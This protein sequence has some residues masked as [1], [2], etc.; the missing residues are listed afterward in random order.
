ME[1]VRRQWHDLAARRRLILLVAGGTIALAFAASRLFGNTQA[2]DILMAVAALVA[3]ADI[4]LR[5]V[6][7]LRRRQV[8]IELLVTIAA[9][10]ALI[11]GEYWEA[12]A[13]TFL[14][15]LGAWLEARTLSRTRAALGKLLDLAPNVA[16]V[17]RGGRDVEV[18]P[19]DVAVGEEILVRSGT[20]IPVDGIVLRGHSAVDEAP[21]T[22]ESIPVE[23]TPGDAVFAGTISH[24][25]VLTI[26]ARG[27]GA[28]T[29]LA[30]II[31][32]V[33]EAQ[34]A[35]APAQKTIERFAAWYTPAIIALAGLTWAL[36]RDIHLALTILVIGCPGALVIATPV[37]FVAG[38]GRAA[39]QGILIKGGEFLETVGKVTTVGFDKTGTLTRGRPELT[40]IVAFAPVTVGGASASREPGMEVL[41]W[42]AIAEA[43]SGHPLARPIMTAAGE[44]LPGVLP[45]ADA[46]ETVVG[47]GVVATW[48]GHVIAVGTRDLMTRR[49]IEVTAEA[50]TLVHRLQSE[51]KTAML[52]GVDGAVVGVLGVQDVP[53]EDIAGVPA[54][55]ERA[56][57]RRIAMLTGDN[58][59][60][61]RTIGEAVGITEIH[62]RLLP[63]DK[64]A[65]IEAARARGEVVAMVGDGIN[66]APALA[67]AD[68]GIAMGAAGSDVALETADVALMT[69]Q[70]GKIADALR[71]SRRTVT[72][73]RQNL[74]IALVT[75]GLLL[76]GVLLR[77]VNMAGGMLI[78]EASVL[79]VILNAMRLLRA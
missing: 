59:E 73:I 36:T 31:H 20:K 58:A 17:R 60:T 61:A 72:V 22:G 78:H 38:I 6:H 19:A 43:G 29:T 21:I 65:W 33:E 77:E 75:V 54:R 9:G 57:I 49:D 71:I 64:L 32:R 74:A 44:R 23:K 45:A 55:L 53:R 27:I 70:P 50:D 79:L 11:I 7:G 52:V 76:A 37:A 15:V 69:D 8:T 67:T 18:D 1:R 42:A 30:R 51:G 16:V 41:R 4:A 2:R 12:A 14:F 28:D 63:E 25:G 47:H 13:V 24:D 48:D 40:D 34:E 35:K 66:D 26:E 10:G 5:A 68:V 46:A 56:G 3:G 39:S 62:A